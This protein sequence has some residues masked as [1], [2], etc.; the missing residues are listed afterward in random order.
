[1]SSPQPGHVL[2]PSK[3]LLNKVHPVTSI[4]QPMGWAGLAGLILA[5]VVGGIL[6]WEEFIIIAVVLTVLFIVAIA[7]VIGRSAYEVKLDLTRLR[8]RVGADAF[9]GVSITNLATRRSMASIFMMPVGKDTSAFRVPRLAGNTSHDESFQVDTSSRAVVPVGPVRSSRGDGL[10]LL[11]RDVIWAEAQEMFVHPRTINLQDSSTGFM[12]DLEGRPTDTLSSSDIA[13][14]ALRDYVVGDDLRH[15]HWKS[16][17][18]TG[19]LLVRQFEET[20]RSH[21][22]ICLSMSVE[23]YESEADFELA[24]SATAS[25]GEQSIREEKDLTIQVPSKSLSVASGPRMLDDFA[26]LEFGNPV[27]SIE[28]VALDA[29]VAAPDASVVIVAVGTPV[30][31]ARLHAATSRFSPDVLSVIL[32]CEVGARLT[33]AVIGSSPV[34]TIGSLEDLPR[35]LRSLEA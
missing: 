6:G 12:K 11:R 24:V 23:D 26:R 25:M 32:R 19:K 18:R 3:P 28:T 4:I 7:F 13:F 2:E 27:A 1:M 22:V 35:A 21:L 31:P 15:V 17:A 16:S 34:L 10:G 30:A 5:L 8:V 9:G 20:R 29:S 33:R 14:H